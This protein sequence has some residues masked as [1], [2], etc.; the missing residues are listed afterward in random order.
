MLAETNLPADCP[1]SQCPG[2]CHG[3][4]FPRQLDG[5][6]LVELVRIP[7]S[8][9]F[10]EVTGTLNT[11]GIIS[12]EFR[13]AR[14]PLQRCNHFIAQPLLNGSPRDRCPICH[15]FPKV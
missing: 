2:S 3:D 8:N 14:L 7:A 5:L 4:Y 12:H 11:F 6:S 1:R 13:T 15:I 10:Q 9:L